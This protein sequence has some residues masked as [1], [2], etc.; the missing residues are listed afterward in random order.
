MSDTTGGQGNFQISIKAARQLGHTGIFLLS[1]TFNPV[2]KLRHVTSFT[3][4][5]ATGK[6]WEKQ[7]NLSLPALAMQLSEAPSGVAQ[8]TPHLVKC[9][10]SSFRL[11]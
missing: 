10:G 3:V 11:N 6:Q 4:V 1:V 7:R 2:K 5:N 9:Y 8:M